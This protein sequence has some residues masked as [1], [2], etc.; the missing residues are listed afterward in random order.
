[1]SVPCT[2]VPLNAITGGDPEALL[3]TEMFPEAVPVAVGKNCAVKA[4][5]EPGLIV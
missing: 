2:P 1:M 5:L 3:L 4:V